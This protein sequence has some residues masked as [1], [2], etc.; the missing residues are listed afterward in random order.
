MIANIEYLEGQFCTCDTGDMRKYSGRAIG[1]II[2]AHH[3]PAGFEQA[4]AS[5]RTDIARGAG[6]E[7]RSC[8]FVS[9]CCQRIG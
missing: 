3:T 4:N 5:V 1:K 7:N 6:D 9:V 2:D 8:H